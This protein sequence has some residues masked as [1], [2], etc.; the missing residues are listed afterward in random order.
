[1]DVR[2]KRDVPTRGEDWHELVEDEGI[3]DEGIGLRAFS[4]LPKMPMTHD[5]FFLRRFSF[6]INVKGDWRHRKGKSLTM[7]SFRGSFDV[8]DLFFGIKIP[9]FCLH[10]CRPFGFCVRRKIIWFDSSFG[11]Y[12][13]KISHQSLQ[14]GPWIQLWASKRN[15]L[16]RWL[17]GIL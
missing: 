11:S 14:V 1:M 10:F 12:P 17:E 7:K 2:S 4:L 5:G 15:Q 3:E 9:Q 13:S 16:L 6:H 8:T